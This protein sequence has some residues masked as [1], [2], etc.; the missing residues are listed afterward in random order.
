MSSLATRQMRSSSS[1]RVR[2]RS[3]G[4]SSKRCVTIS[5]PKLKLRR[6][7]RVKKG[8]ERKII[9]SGLVS[10]CICYRNMLPQ[11]LISCMS[12]GRFVHNFCITQ[13]L[14]EDIPEGAEW[15]CTS[16]INASYREKRIGNTMLVRANNEFDAGKATKRNLAPMRLGAHVEE[17]TN[18]FA[19]GFTPKKSGL[20]HGGNEELVSKQ[21]Q[22]TIATF[23]PVCSSAH[24]SSYTPKLPLCY[25]RMRT[26]RKSETNVRMNSPETGANTE[27]RV[28]NRS[29]QSRAPRRRKYLSSSNPPNTSLQGID[30]KAKFLKSIRGSDWMHMNTLHS[31]STRHGNATTKRQQYFVP[32]LSKFTP[33]R[34]VS[35]NGPGKSRRYLSQTAFEPSTRN[36]ENTTTSVVKHK[37]TKSSSLKLKRNATVYTPLDSVLEEKSE[38][39]VGEKEPEVQAGSTNQ[40]DSTK[41]LCS[42]HAGAEV[43]E[44]ADNVQ[45]HR[46]VR[47]SCDVRASSTYDVKDALHPLTYFPPSSP[48]EA[49]LQRTLI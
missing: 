5:P 13:H 2:T 21:P 37:V 48:W 26:A 22:P 43:Q 3:S 9:A 23:L 41:K 31:S 19:T 35:V 27:L 44:I 29:S 12:C 16:C 34:S 30:E 28:M 25:P 36:Q 39:T 6:S 15:K 11:A 4:F 1:K 8:T 46:H 33:L 17:A 47:L 18:S 38:I 10:C 45:V 24:P 49:S 7:N 20:P 42:P 32:V 40:L 14:G